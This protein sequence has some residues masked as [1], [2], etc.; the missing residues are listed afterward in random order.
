MRKTP[1]PAL[2]KFGENVRAAREDKSWTQENLADR[3]DV[4]Q[5]F[6]SGIERGTRNPT[7]ITISKL[8]KALGVGAADLCGGIES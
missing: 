1:H 5:T 6:I 8:A 4:D 2:V 7:V 3:A